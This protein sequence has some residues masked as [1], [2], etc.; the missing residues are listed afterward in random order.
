MANDYI[1]QLTKLPSYEI[2]EELGSSEEGLI[3]PNPAND[4]ETVALANEVIRCCMVGFTECLPV[5]QRK[6]FFLVIGMGLPYKLAA[7]IL[8]CRF[9]QDNAAPG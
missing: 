2:A 9:D 8:D 3:D 5:N 1:R 7:A 4:P 6:V